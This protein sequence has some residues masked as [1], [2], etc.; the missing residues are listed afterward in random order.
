MYSLILQ[1]THE[2]AITGILDLQAIQCITDIIEDDPYELIKNASNINS[3]ALVLSLSAD[4][5]EGLIRGLKYYRLQFPKTRIIVISDITEVGNPYLAT[6]VSAGVYDIITTDTDD[7]AAKFEE[8]L[9]NPMNYRDVSRYV[10]DTD[11]GEYTPQMTKVKTVYQK[12]DIRTVEKIIEKEK[13][14][15]EQ[16]GQS[17][18]SVVGNGSRIG[19]TTT[20]LTIAKVLSDNG[21]DT[22]V[23]EANKNC[24]FDYIAKVAGIKPYPY[25]QVEGI[26]F[27]PYK[28]EIQ[29]GKAIDNGHKYII[30]DAG[31]LSALDN[32]VLNYSHARFIISGS[33]EWEIGWLEDYIRSVDPVSAKRN[34]Y[35]FN[36]TSEESYKIIKSNME[37]LKTALLPFSPDWSRPADETQELILQL[38][39]LQPK[40]SS[41]KKVSSIVS[42]IKDKATNLVKGVLHRDQNE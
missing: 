37:N 27:Y 35:L 14:I 10:G 4:Y 41:M 42:N 23:V 24:H 2:P 33:Q 3:D 28:D 19:T 40:E 1:K 20:A 38:F 26:T 29:I 16:I 30:C 18:I 34:T 9:L 5:A 13:V 6:I 8:I 39:N 21:I 32:T 17:I 12:G 15:V 25:F 22:A 36:F 11:T 31:T 7:L